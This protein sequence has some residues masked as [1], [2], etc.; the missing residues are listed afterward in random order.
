MNSEDAATMESTIATDERAA[1]AAAAAVDIRN[2]F[3]DSNQCRRR[4]ER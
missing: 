4:G 2:S 1:L 3:A